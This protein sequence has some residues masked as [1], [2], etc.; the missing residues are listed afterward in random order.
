MNTRKITQN[1]PRQTPS[2]ISYPNIKKCS[3]YTHVF[4]DTIRSIAVLTASILAKF[5]PSITAEEA[6][7]SAAVAVSVIILF[8]LFPLFDG[9]KTTAVELLAIRREEKMMSTTMKFHGVANNND[10]VADAVLEGNSNDSED[11]E[12]NQVLFV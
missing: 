2:L 5:V 11:G 8:A 7:A 4:A 3:A 1:L 6:D 12:G 9:L 10:D